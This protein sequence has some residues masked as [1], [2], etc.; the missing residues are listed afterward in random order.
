MSKFTNGGKPSWLT[1][2]L[3]L[4]VVLGVVLSVTKLSDRM[5]NKGAGSALL[6]QSVKENTKDII[7]VVEGIGEVADSLIAVKKAI[8]QRAKN[9]D[10]FLRQQD[11][12]AILD[13]V[14]TERLMEFIGQQVDLNKQQ[15]KFNGKIEEHLIR[16]NNN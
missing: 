9:W 5:F 2:I 4:S 3:A 15:V 11:R 13:S 8:E 6:A 12:K 7:G 16:A 1:W 14:N 10:K